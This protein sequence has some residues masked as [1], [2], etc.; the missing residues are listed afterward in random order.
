VNDREVTN[1]SL[2]L[3][4][5]STPRA[6]FADSVLSAAAAPRRSPRRWPWLVAAAAA[7]AA[8]VLLLVRGGKQPAS[9]SGARV[10]TARETLP[11]GARAV[12]V[13]EVDAVLAWQVRGDSVDVDQSLGSVFYRV[14]PD[15]APFVIE[16]PAG[17]VRVHG[18]C[19]RV[20]VR[21]V[22]KD[23]ILAAGV[24]AAIAT[25]VTVFVYEGR[26]T[27]H[28]EAGRADAAAG[29]E[30]EMA[31]GKAP[32]ARP[33]EQVAVGKA[34]PGA[35]REELLA[36]VRIFSREI[37]ELT[38][39]VKSLEAK[40]EAMPRSTEAGEPPRGKMS[41]F[42]PEELQWMAK[43]CQ[44]RY[45]V[46][47]YTMA[48]GAQLDA[49]D[50]RELH[51]TDNQL[52]AVNQVLAAGDNSIIEQMRDLYVELTGDRR[53]AEALSP[54]NLQ[55]EIFEKSPPDEL[56]HAFQR[57]AAERAGLA[58]PP[59]NE[60]GMSP[61]ERLLRL[62]ERAGDDY[63]RRLADV[64]GPDQAASLRRKGVGMGRRVQSGCPEQ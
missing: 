25:A 33:H 19:F 32:V 3:W 11:L 16:T 18:S 60:A 45:D 42:S 12:A 26:V 46:P 24:G 52:A 9:T 51:L 36:Q 6:G 10:T 30:L 15:G 48:L 41:D 54:H 57:L 55:H 63:Q 21:A 5:S 53:V 62:L 56:H 29:Q 61:V 64:L 35:T 14:D 31:A 17:R 20:E 28:N 13:A 58:R 39:K 38:R 27:A 1:R 59:A 8:V 49:D 22:N 4:P 34:P 2:A 44:I 50:A 7:L 43:N 23:R 37:D 47:G 40:V